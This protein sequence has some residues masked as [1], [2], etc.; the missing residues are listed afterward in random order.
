MSL[1]EKITWSQRP[2][3]SLALKILLSLS[4]LYAQSATD[5]RQ[6]GLALRSQQQ[7]SQAIIAFE[8][9]VALA[10]HDPN[11]RVIL[12][13]TYHLAGQTNLAKRSLWR[14]VFLNP[15]AA[16]AFNA[17]GIVYLTQG[18]LL[19]AITL[20]S[21]ATLIKPNNE[22]A[23]YNLS[24]AYQRWGLWHLA[25]NYSNLAINLEPNNPHP[26]IAKSMA[27]WQS[28]DRPRAKQI[29]NQALNLDPRYG[30]PNF[31]GYLKE[32]GFSHG[33]I[34]LVRQILDR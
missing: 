29:L 34:S 16:P 5:Y 15:V 13:W 4:L 1:L 25:I 17:L 30:D 18:E 31:L 7:F 32:A 33:Q 2:I 19:P 24:L 6:Q 12:G 9:S 23:Y 3:A 26:L 21:W 27:L 28:G 8:K 14:A 11:G 10:P 22:I 20:H